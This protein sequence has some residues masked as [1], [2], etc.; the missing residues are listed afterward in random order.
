MGRERVVPPE[1]LRAAIEARRELGEEL[2][3]HLIDSFVERIERRVDER[4]RERLPRQRNSDHDVAVT[5]VS[6]LVAI[7][8]I[9][10]AGGIA[11]LPAIVAVCAA[12]VL[13]NVVARR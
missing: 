11:G 5:I 8:L 12:L 1:E 7:P 3:P 10:I 6:L 9:A 2:E 4:L 13:V